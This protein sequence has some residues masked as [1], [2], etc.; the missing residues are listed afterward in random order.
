[1]KVGSDD[2]HDEND[3]AGS[4]KTDKD[5]QHQN[6]KQNDRGDQQF[7]KQIS[8]YSPAFIFGVL[9]KEKHI[10]LTSMSSCKKRK[11]LCVFVWF[12]LSFC[13]PDKDFFMYSSICY[14]KC[15]KYQRKS[16]PLNCPCNT[17]IY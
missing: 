17:K 8:M 5:E 16:L 12:N 15:S 9:K 10:R 11:D 3:A 7:S 1:M 6:R 2:V 13:Y 14:F 4:V